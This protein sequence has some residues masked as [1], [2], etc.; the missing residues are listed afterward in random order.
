MQFYQNIPYGSIVMDNFHF[1]TFWTS[2]KPQ[3]MEHG[4]WQSPGLDIISINVCV[5]FH[6]NIPYGSRDRASF[7]FSEFG[8]RQSLDR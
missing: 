6:Q 7:T 4:I 2:A 8:Q 1:F 3:P 5:K